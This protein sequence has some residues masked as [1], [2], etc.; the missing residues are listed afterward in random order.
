[1]ITH[2]ELIKLARKY[3]VPTTKRNKDGKYGKTRVTVKVLK[4]RLTRAG[5]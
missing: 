3:K 4:S 5:G 2:S 1:M